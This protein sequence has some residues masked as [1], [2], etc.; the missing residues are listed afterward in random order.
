MNAYQLAKAEI[1]T[2]E[3]GEGSNP[4]VLGYFRDAGHE[5]ISDDA[6]PW[7]AAFVGAMLERS[8]VKG[9]GKL[10]ARSYLNWGKPVDLQDAREG[11]VVV[12]KR[13]NSSWQGH[14]AFYVRH[15]GN[16]IHVLGGNQTDQV[17]ITVY[18]GASLIGVRRAIESPRPEPKPAPQRPDIPETAQKPSAGLISA[19]LAFILSIFGGRK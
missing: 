10:T 15:Q 16:A 19:L 12:F 18:S 11:D 13:G 5:N 2:F 4:K 8:G 14:V 7:C 1:G 17:N 3:W 6:V 9:T